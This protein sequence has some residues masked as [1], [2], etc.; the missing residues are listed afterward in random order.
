MN[1]INKKIGGVTSLTVLYFNIRRI[2]A[3]VAAGVHF[4]HEMLFQYMFMSTR[5]RVGFLGELALQEAKEQNF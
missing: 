3:Q 5:F 2:Q 1:Y 4:R